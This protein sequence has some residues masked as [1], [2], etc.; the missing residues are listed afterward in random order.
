MARRHGALARRH[1]ALARRHG[2]LARRHG[3]LARRRGALARRD[4]VLARRHDVFLVSMPDSHKIASE[5]ISNK[6]KNFYGPRP[7]ETP[8][9]ETTA[10]LQNSAYFVKKW[11]GTWYM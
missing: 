10:W 7:H 5:P 11:V 3:V 1:G 6:V 4:G 8:S 2:A 9:H